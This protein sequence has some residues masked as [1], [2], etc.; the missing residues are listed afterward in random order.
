MLA[1][2]ASVGDLVAGDAL[3][4]GRHEQPVAVGR[5][6]PLSGV[7]RHRRLPVAFLPTCLR[8]VATSPILLIHRSKAW[9]GFLL[10]RSRERMAESV[11]VHR[12][13]LLQAWVV[14]PITWAAEAWAAWAVAAACLETCL[15]AEG[16][17]RSST[18]RRCL[19]AA[20]IS[21]GPGRY[22]RDAQSRP[23][24]SRSVAGFAP[25]PPPAGSAGGS[26]TGGTGG[27]GSSSVAPPPPPASGGG[28]QRGGSKE[29]RDVKKPESEA[30]AAKR[31]EKRKLEEKEKE[32]K[33][34]EEQRKREVAQRERERLL[35][36]IPMTDDVE[37]ATKALE[38][39]EFVAPFKFE[40]GIPPV[41]C[42]PKLI[43]IPFDMKKFVKFRYD[44]QWE[45]NRKYEIIPEPD[46][47]ITIDLVDPQAYDPIPGATLDPKDAALLSAHAFAL[48]TGEKKSAAQGAKAMRQE[49]TWC[50]RRRCWGTTCTTP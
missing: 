36:I 47:G 9:E 37:G 22:R 20:K 42:D 43:D 49:V 35:N 2:V 28:A 29:N 50:A 39:G 19:R 46:L 12:V 15:A 24:A 41:P 11:E 6:F 13:S 33:R 17:R 16:I 26:S 45:L 14:L 7:W 23:D 27:G 21:L 40:M 4:A 48:A 18:R 30:D 44:S 5:Q 8:E 1:C 3:N 25:P 10:R 34:A 31:R 32:K 38:M